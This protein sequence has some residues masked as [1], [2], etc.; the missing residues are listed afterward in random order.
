MLFSSNKKYAKHNLDTFAQLLKSTP[1]YS[2]KA[3][4]TRKLNKK[5]CIIIIKVLIKR[6]T[7]INAYILWKSLKIIEV[8]KCIS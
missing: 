8:N 5:K 7:L 2:R 4:K 3:S 6:K 1:E